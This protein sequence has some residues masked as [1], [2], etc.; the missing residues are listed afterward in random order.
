VAIYLN[1]QGYKAKQFSSCST[2]S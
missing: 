2:G 1:M